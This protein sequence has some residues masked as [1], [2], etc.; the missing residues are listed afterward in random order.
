[1]L[2]DSDPLYGAGKYTKTIY[3]V[4]PT[5]GSGHHNS[6]ANMYCEILLEL[7]YKV[8]LLTPREREDI[9]PHLRDYAAL[10]NL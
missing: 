9:S 10:Q 8:V 7:G 6:Y 2:H 3:C 1:M 5:M 4:Q